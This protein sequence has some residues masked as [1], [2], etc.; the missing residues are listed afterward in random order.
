MWD[1]AAPFTTRVDQLRAFGAALPPS[2]YGPFTATEWTSLSYEGATACLRVPYP[3]VPTL[4]VNS[5]L[6]NITATAGARLVA[7]RFPNSTF[8][9]IHNQV[10][11][12]A[13]DDRDRCAAPIVRRFIRALDAGDTG[14]AAHTAEVRWSTASRVAAVAAATMADAIQ[15]WQLNYGGTDRG[16]RGGRWSWS[17]GE[18]TRFRFR[19][20][21][22]VRD[23]PVFGRATWRLRTRA[24][25]ASLTIPGRGRLRA[26]WNVGDELAVATLSGRIDG[27]RLR[28]AMLAP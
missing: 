4:V 3:A 6:D 28:A 17:G 12:S 1:P 2:R 18:L 10:H 22:F 11:V 26:G 5:D 8:V 14:C 24:V 7:S 13:L 23:V 16:L 25:R 19:G 21:R 9:E 27:R 15:R 20:A